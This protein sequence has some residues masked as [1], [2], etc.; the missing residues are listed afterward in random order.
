MSL[1]IQPSFHSFFTNLFVSPLA[2]PPI[3]FSL[4]FCGTGV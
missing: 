1:S 2:Y 4:I 3:F